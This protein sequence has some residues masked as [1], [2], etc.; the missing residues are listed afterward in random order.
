MA[1]TTTPFDMFRTRLM[2]QTSKEKVYSG[3]ID[4]I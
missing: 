2:N 4:C 3:L 1:C